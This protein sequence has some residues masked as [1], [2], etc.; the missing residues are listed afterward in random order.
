MR[1]GTSRLVAPWY[2]GTID[3]DTPLLDDPLSGA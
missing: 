1:F 3:L 2:F